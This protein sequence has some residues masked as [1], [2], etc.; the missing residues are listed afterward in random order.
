MFMLLIYCF[1]F[2]KIVVLYF[3]LV[4]FFLW[5]MMVLGVDLGFFKW[6]WLVNKWVMFL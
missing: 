3:L 5:D 2:D 6:E 1:I 4:L